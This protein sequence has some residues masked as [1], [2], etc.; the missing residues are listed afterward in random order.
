MI[1]N[2]SSWLEISKSAFE[3]NVQQY[4]KIIGQ[5]A[6]AV[7][8]KANAYGHGLSEIAQLCERIN[9]VDWL[10]TVNLS[11]ALTIRA[12]NS[13]NPILVLG[14][15]DADLF[16]AINQNIAFV[17]S[18][19]QNAQYLNDF[20]KKHVCRFNVHIK[21]DTGLSRFGVMPENT[22]SFIQQL[23]TLSHLSIQGIC[24]HLAESQKLDQTYTD[25]QLSAF[26]HVLAQL[27]QAKIIIPLKHA[28]NSAATTSPDFSAYNF[29]RV[30]IGAYGYWPS[31]SNK[32]RTQKLYPSFT[33][34]PVLTWKTRI[35]Q[36]KKILPKT[37]VGYD[38][39]YKTTKLTTVAFIP[40]GYYGGYDPLLSNNAHVRINEKSAPIIGRIAMNLMTIDITNI[41]S[42]KIGDEVLV[43]GNY[44]DINGYCL[45]AKTGINNVRYLTTRINPNL[46]RII[47]V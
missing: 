7:V 10:C 2:P 25:K 22:L 47:T 29:F 21:I 12:H 37:D 36:V 6:L 13:R 44:E 38:R 11:E 4:K 20:C 15:I 8:I 5:R 31:E 14:F 9:A 1:V 39:T 24:T 19:Y 30:G 46:K 3:H 41:S 45:A 18:D 16:N 40:V 43:L 34:K 23:K 17:I 42:T 27:E 26:N 28:A 35:I 32:E 33:L